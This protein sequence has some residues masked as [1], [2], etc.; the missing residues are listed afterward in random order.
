MHWTDIWRGIS[1]YKHLWNIRVTFLFSLKTKISTVN[2]RNAFLFLLRKNHL[3]NL[4]VFNSLYIWTPIRGTFHFLLQLKSSQ[5]ILGTFLIS[6]LLKLF[7]QI[8]GTFLL[9]LHLKAIYKSYIECS[10]CH[11]N[12]NL[13]HCS[14]LNFWRTFYSLLFKPTCDIIITS[15]ALLMHS[16]NAHN[17]CIDAAILREAN[18]KLGK[19][20]FSLLK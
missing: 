12:K 20:E 18:F 16:R 8:W 3:K 9:L 19:F 5:S 14:S 4:P 6:L 17:C 2:L 7:H 11:F 13:S 15:R 10:S 1:T